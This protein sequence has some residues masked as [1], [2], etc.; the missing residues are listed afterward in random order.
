MQN[1][2]DNLCRSI[3]PVPN[4]EV[5]GPTSWAIRAQKL[6]NVGSID[7]WD[8]QW[9]QCRCHRFEFANGLSL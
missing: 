1:I 4:Y 6:V 3:Y 8:A 7:C 9:K 2:C 5:M